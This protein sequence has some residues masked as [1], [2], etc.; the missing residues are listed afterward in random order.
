MEADAYWQLAEPGGGEFG[1]CCINA[2][3]RDYGRLG[4]FALRDGRLADGTRVL[5]EGWMKESTAPS[6]GYPGYGYLWWLNDDGTFKASGIF[7]QGIYVDRA[8]NL[9]IALQSAR[10]RASE[11]SDW[12]LQDALYEA[13][14]DAVSR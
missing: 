14:R 12:A 11:D 7:G 1:G 13:L 9:V 10:T 6:K 4:L 3:L 2:T 8:R 5:P